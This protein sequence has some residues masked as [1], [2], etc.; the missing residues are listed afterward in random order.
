[1]ENNS[2]KFMR[3]GAFSPRE[4]I[5]SNKKRNIRKEFFPFVKNNS[6]NNSKK[7]IDFPLHL[8][9]FVKSQE[10]SEIN[11]TIKKPHKNKFNIKLS[12][13]KPK[14]LNIRKFNLDNIIKRTEKNNLSRNLNI[15]S[16]SNNNNALNIDSFNS[17]NSSK[18]IDI[19]KLLDSIKSPRIK[20]KSINY[21]PLNINTKNSP[22]IINQIGID[23]TS[24][25]K[26]STKMNNLSNNSIENDLSLMKNL[27]ST[28]HRNSSFNNFNKRKMSSVFQTPHRK[29]YFI[30]NSIKKPKLKEIKRLFQK[31]INGF[32]L[33]KKNSSKNIA[34]INNI[35]NKEKDEDEN[36]NNNNIN[37]ISNNDIKNSDINNS[38]NKNILNFSFKLS[39]N[40]NKHK[41]MS[42][43]NLKNGLSSNNKKENNNH[44]ENSENNAKEIN[45]LKKKSSFIINDRKKLSFDAS[46]II[47]DENKNENDKE[48]NNEVEFLKRKKSGK[49]YHKARSKNFHHSHKKHNIKMDKNNFYSMNIEKENQ[50][51]FLEK[52][53][54]IKYILIQ[55]EKQIIREK[56]SILLNMQIKTKNYINT[57]KR[58][59]IVEA[60]ELSG[61]HEFDKIKEIYFRQITQK[62]N[63][64][65]IDEFSSIEEIDTINKNCN[66]SVILSIYLLSSY[67]FEGLSIT[68]QVDIKRRFAK[69]FTL[70]KNQENDYGIMI[71]ERLFKKEEETFKRTKSKVFKFHNINN[72]NSDWMFTSKNLIR[73]QEITLKANNFDEWNIN[74]DRKNT[75]NRVSFGRSPSMSN[76]KTIINVLNRKNNI[77]NMSPKRMNSIS[78]S[79]LKRGKSLKETYKNK[80]KKVINKNYSILQMKK[81]FSRNFNNNKEDD[82]ILKD[83]KKSKYL[84]SNSLKLFSSNTVTNHKLGEYYYV[85]LN[86]IIQ[87]LYKNFV[88][89][90]QKFQK[91]IDINKIIYEGNTLLIISTKEGNFAITKY[92]CQ[93]GADV[94]IQNDEGNTALHYAIANQ[95]FSIVDL[96]KDNGA[97]ED[98]INNKGLSP[99]DCIEHGL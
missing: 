23:N 52:L 26:L 96:L 68:S 39:Q 84:S 93:K 74:D 43:I 19:N 35:I 20:L 83:D 30:R 98:L 34:D 85:L 15:S 91:R 44:K 31:E 80:E 17:F 22:I 2:W 25:S 56:T 9:L 90:F 89:V 36:I 11:N 71:Q 14:E 40:N 41:S 76:V 63:I 47:E 60:T 37:N 50:N 57:N 55:Q 13:F 48:K 54:E 27:K 99:W 79:P 10:S 53:N 45:K 69:Q 61:L 7:V 64:K 38:S 65:N 4:S 77:Q 67:E 58:K 12:S 28:F 16:N 24:T 1:M 81:F 46:K 94:N 73:I 78:H 8:T 82:I 51:K 97:K 70:K 72:Y 3:R 42:I 95:F 32:D 62:I 5:H 29:S 86:C 88:S 75:I 49:H 18:M 33:D 92:L 87:S 6:N 21:S 66:L 59:N